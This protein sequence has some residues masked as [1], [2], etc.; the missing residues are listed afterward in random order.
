M[1]LSLL[2][3]KSMFVILS[4][5]SFLRIFQIKF[6]VQNTS[7]FEEIMFYFLMEYILFSANKDQIFQTRLSRQSHTLHELTLTYL[8]CKTVKNYS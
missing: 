2:F 6:Q 7:R 1:E 5:F 4:L 3:G 8:K